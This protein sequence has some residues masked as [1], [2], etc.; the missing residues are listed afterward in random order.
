M[1]AKIFAYSNHF[2]IILLRNFLVN[3]EA[4]GVAYDGIDVAVGTFMVRCLS[5]WQPTV[6]YRHFNAQIVVEVVANGCTDAVAE[7]ADVVRR[8]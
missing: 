7:V 6:L 1:P 5:A 2:F 8:I 4:G 3:R